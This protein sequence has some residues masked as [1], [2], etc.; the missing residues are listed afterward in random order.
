ME[1][2]LTKYFIKRFIFALITI[3]AI[4]SLN[5]YLFRIM[6]GNPI[7]LLYRSPELSASRI[8]I[9]TEQFGLNKPLWEQ[10]FIY[11]YNTLTGNWGISFY[12]KQPVFNVI[13]PA[14][15]NSLILLIPA[16]FLSIILGIF[17]GIISAWKRGTRIDFAFLGTA[18]AFYAMPT[19]WFGAILILL[20]LYIG[21][22]PISGMYTIG[23]YNSNPISQLI[24]L[25]S[26]LVLPL[27]T[28]TLV[29][30]GQF[31]IIMRNS[32]IDVF[33]EDYI[34]TAKAKG[35]DEKWIIKK[36]AVPNA[37]LPMVSIIAIN[38]GLVVTG[39]ILTET[40]FSWPGVGL[41]IYDS[42]MARDYPVLQGTF[43]IV[44]ITVVMAN[45][46]ADIIYARLDP[47][48]RYQ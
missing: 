35:A 23:A 12:Y 5:F 38:F 44:A 3:I 22:I 16:T 48:I 2:S 9:L 34:F 1:R 19:F 6:P 17:T 37:M 27:I 7:I 14:M 18:L 31:T 10:Y 40:I 29:Y 46:I 8:K 15:I 21:G 25:L 39:A 20:A 41:L 26:H 36:H 30:Y 43:L 47:R 28:L 13:I 42:I 45:F 11:V 32:L 33:T 24:D 4:I